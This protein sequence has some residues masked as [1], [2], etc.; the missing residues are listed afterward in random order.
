MDLPMR[1]WPGSPPRNGSSS[2]R[3]IWTLAALPSRA[4]LRRG[5]FATLPFHG[6]PSTV[7]QHFGSFLATGGIHVIQGHLVVI[8]PGSVR[9]RRL[10]PARSG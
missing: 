2:S 5:G 6:T 7:V 9:R 8:T 10:R 4:G 3:R 1:N